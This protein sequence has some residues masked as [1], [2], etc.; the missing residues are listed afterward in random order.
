MTA[1]FKNVKISGW[2]WAWKI[3]LGR[4]QWLAK[5]RFKTA[6]SRCTKNRRK[7]HSGKM[8]RFTPNQY[9]YILILNVLLSIS[10]FCTKNLGSSRIRRVMLRVDARGASPAPSWPY[11]FLGRFFHLTRTQISHSNQN[12]SN[13][14]K[15][16]LRIYSWCHSTSDLILQIWLIQDL[17]LYTLIFF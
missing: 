16:R 10:F 14:K 2:K 12:E 11:C 9:I 1:L 7:L 15:T 5:K 3:W 13:R 17:F 6:K 4:S 8:Y